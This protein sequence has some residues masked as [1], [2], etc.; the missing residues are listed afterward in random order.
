MKALLMTCLLVAAL[1]ALPDP[2]A[3]QDRADSYNGAS[4]TGYPAYDASSTVPFGHFLYGF[5]NMAFCH[6]P[7]P[8][9]FT[10]RDL[11][12][13]LFVGRAPAG[14]GP[15]RFSLCVYVPLGSAT[16]G[17]ERTL[18]P[19]T[20]VNWVAP[21]EIPDYAMGAYLQVR[22]PAGGVSVLENFSVFWNR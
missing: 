22:F 13:V 2:A 17:P 9:N 4:C 16:C 5:R 8:D 21:P 14:V 10:P 7:M 1:G 19:T 15:V 18:T 6:F 20:S 12:Y 11:W 3:A